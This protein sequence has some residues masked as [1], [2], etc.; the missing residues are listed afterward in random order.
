MQKLMLPS[1]N[2]KETSKYMKNHPLIKKISS[3]IRELELGR[4][5]VMSNASAQFLRSRHSSQGSQISNLSS[6]AIKLE[7]ALE[8]A[9]LEIDFKY[10]DRENKQRKMEW[11]QMAKRLDQAKAKLNAIKAQSFDAAPT[12]VPPYWN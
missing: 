12:S 6:A 5:Y 8:V 3:Q 2:Q 1:G 10:T 4:T 9:A 11:V 7:A